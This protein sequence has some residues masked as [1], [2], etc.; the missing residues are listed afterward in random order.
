M[1]TKVRKIGSEFWQILENDITTKIIPQDS[2][3][4]RFKDGEIA[5]ANANDDRA[6]TS[7]LPLSDFQ[8]EQGNTFATIEDFIL[9]ITG[10]ATS[11]IMNDTGFGFYADGQ[12]VEAAPFSLAANT[13]INLPNNASTTNEA[14]LPNDVSSF[15]DGTKITPKNEGDTI[16]LNINLNV[17]T[18]VNNSWIRLGIDIGGA[19]GIIFPQVFVLP[20]ETNEEQ[21]VTFVVNGFC[22]STFVPNGGVVKVL[23]NNPLMIYDISYVV[24]RHHRSKTHN[25]T[26][27][28]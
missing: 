12:Y 22:G 7:F 23:S 25:G 9:S 17:K 28:I 2:V 6:Y 19:L 20:K 11:N 10:Q 24:L 15:Y 21:P 1:A 16:D 5:V 13:L 4:F 27:P 18:S 14:N 26:T 8:D 3:E